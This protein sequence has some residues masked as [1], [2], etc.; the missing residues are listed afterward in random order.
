MVLIDVRFVRSR[1]IY[2]RRDALNCSNEG[3][4]LGLAGLCVIA[5]AFGPI[6]PAVSLADPSPADDVVQAITFKPHV[7]L[8]GRNNG[9]IWV[10]GPLPMRFGVFRLPRCC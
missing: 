2:S 1:G 8:Q 10:F 7:Q 9:E 5:S 3:E 6:L 4:G